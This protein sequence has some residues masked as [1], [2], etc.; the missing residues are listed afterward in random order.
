[1]DTVQ[2][3]TT[4]NIDIGYTLAGV[5]QR[6]LAVVIDIFLVAVTFSLLSIAFSEILS[7][8]SM[9][10]M[11]IIMS[12]LGFLYFLLM[13]MLFN[14]QTI[15]KMAMKIRVVKL[16]GSRPG[17]SAYLLRWIMIPIDY[18][19]SGGIA[20]VFIIF[21][22]RAQRL[23]DLLAGTTVVKVKHERK[24]LTKTREVLNSV[25]DEHVQM[26]PDAR[27]L[28]DKDIRLIKAAIEAYN[29][30]FKSAPAWKL[31]E[32]LES[33]L[34]VT[35][36]EPPLTFLRNLLKDYYYQAKKVEPKDRI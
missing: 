14:G 9:N 26:Y 5:F 21:G 3:R 29:R 25:D 22:P 12:I 13:E 10:L 19:L 23:G 1:M 11:A 32:K 36:K 8:E 16:D 20:L 35:A 7:G 31:K 34:N 6:I 30:D 28:S 2:V 4:Q 18:S 27:K 24:V 33:R 15:G 17:F